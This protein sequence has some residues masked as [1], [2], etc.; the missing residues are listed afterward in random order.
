MLINIYINVDIFY[1][2][3]VIV[4]N[5]YIIII[6]M[7]PITSNTKAFTMTS[8]ITND[9]KCN[10]SYVMNCNIFIFMYIIIHFLS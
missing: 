1:H 9:I 6:I 3:I 2:F 10:G 7:L 8:V 5:V 4:V